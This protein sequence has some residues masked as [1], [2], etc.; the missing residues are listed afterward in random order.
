MNNT[1]IVIGATGLVG[2]ELVAR[3][4]NADHIDKVVS[5]TR[6]PVNNASDNVANHV[7]DF[8]RLD[9]L[10]NSELT[11]F[12]GDMLFSCLG[13]T[14]SQ[15]GSLAKQREVDLDYQLKAAKLAHEQGVQELYLVS[16]SG[17]NALSPSPYL[18]MKGQLEEQVKQ[19]GFQRLV[20]FQPS[21]LLGVRA[22]YRVGESLAAKFIPTLCRLPGLRR[23]R[24][25]HGWQVAQKMV[26]ISQQSNQ[27][28]QT[29]SLD[30]V[31]PST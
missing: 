6:R 29:L 12:R 15:A 31:F 1:A 3:L 11:Y 25:I 5:I 13:T 30:E 21:L 23:Y 28:S 24:P 4:A 18:R 9:E 2:T 27:D 22:E 26:E 14:R 10:S 20:I 19:V 7:I 16:S 17:A 8:A